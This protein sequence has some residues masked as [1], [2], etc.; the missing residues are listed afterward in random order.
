MLRREMPDPMAT[1]ALAWKENRPLTDDEFDLVITTIP[2]P[3]TAKAFV[4]ILLAVDMIDETQ[5]SSAFYVR[6][7]MNSE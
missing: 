4:S 6:P 3:A 5:A 1:I 7:E 2:S